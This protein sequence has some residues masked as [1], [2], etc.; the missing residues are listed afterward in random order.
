M[1]VTNPEFIPRGQ[2]TFIVHIDNRLG[3]YLLSALEK[4]SQLLR[5]HVSRYHMKIL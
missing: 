4:T 2:V 3:G 5:G 1:S